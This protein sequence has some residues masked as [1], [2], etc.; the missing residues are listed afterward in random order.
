MTRGIFVRDV[1]LFDKAK[2]KKHGTRNKHYA[3]V[4]TLDGDFWYTATMTEEL[5]NSVVV[6]MENRFNHVLFSGYLH[7]VPLM[8]DYLGLVNESRQQ[9]ELTSFECLKSQ[10][11]VPKLM[12]SGTVAPLEFAPG[13]SEGYYLLNLR[14]PA[15]FSVDDKDVQESL[16]EEMD[17]GF[18]DGD[19]LCVDDVEKQ[20][21]DMQFSDFD[22]EILGVG[23]AV[24]ES[25]KDAGKR[26]EKSVKSTTAR[27]ANIVRSTSAE[28]SQIVGISAEGSKQKHGFL[29]HFL[30]AKRGTSQGSKNV[31]FKTGIASGKGEEPSKGKASG[32][33]KEPM[34]DFE[35][36]DLRGTFMMDG[37]GADPNPMLSSLVKRVATTVVTVSDDFGI[38]NAEGS[39]GSNRS[40]DSTASLSSDPDYD[41]LLGLKRVRT[42]DTASTKKAKK[43]TK[44]DLVKFMQDIVQK[45]K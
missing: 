8:Q 23:T 38:E 26:I 43:K 17:D 24:A 5:H 7:D 35:E 33:G 9:I 31:K 22:K 6:S 20:V 4:F 40:N 16:V 19:I 34:R 21:A 13:P 28:G 32:K 12:T 10:V 25:S 3:P 14:E 11:E 29:A 2:V 42:V 37:V 41:G 1:G 36:V 27:G 44:S 45:R 30:A 18:D 39:N 15:A